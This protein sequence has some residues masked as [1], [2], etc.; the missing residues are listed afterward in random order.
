MKNYLSEEFF[1]S[2]RQLLLKMRTTCIL[3]IIFAS[4]LLATN[5]NSQ[6]A[7]VN[8]NLKN[9]SV[10]QIIRAIENQTDYLFVYDKNEI[11]LTRQ[12]DVNAEN[13]S[14]AEVLSVIFNGT[15]VKYGVIGSNIVLMPDKTVQQQSFTV[16]GRVTD[17]SGN[18]L[19]GVTVVIQDSSK[20]TITDANGN[21]S[22]GNVPGNATLLFSFVGMKQQEI[23]VAGKNTINVMMIE[24]TIGIE[25]VVAVG[26]GTVKKSD[27]TGSV[28]SVSS[29]S[30]LDQPASSANS[31]LAGRAPGVTVR[32]MNG[33][34]GEGWTIRIRGANSL[35]GGNDPLVVVD[36]NYSSIPNMY[37]I[38]SIEILKDA[39]ATAIYGSRGAN[40]VI[41]VK[42]KRGT[43]G[44]PKLSF[45]SDF[46]FD[47]VPQRY[48]LMDAYEFAEFNNSAGAYPF[49][50]EEIAYYKT[51]RGTNWQNEILQTGFSQ[52][53]KAAFSGGTKNVRFYVSP[54]YKKTT[55][56]IINT[57]AS[58]YGLS[59]KVDMDLSDRITVQVETNMGK[60][61]N[62]NPGIAQGGGKGS[63]PLTA[64][65][66]W[67]PTEPV[68]ESD[69][70][71]NRLGIGTGT[72]LNP[73]L[74]TTIQNTNYSY[75]GNG[76]GNLKIKIIDGLEFDAK[77]SIGF[78]ADGN[79]IFVSKNFTGIAAAAS[80]TSYEGTTWLVNSF[81]TYSKE[82][83]KVHNFSAMA[84]FEETKG[85]RNSLSGSANIL[86]IES[87]SWYNLGLAAPNISVGSNYDNSAMRSY[88]G[89][90]NYNYD[91]RYY[92]TANFRA[93]GSSKFKGDNQFGYFPSFA[94]A[95]KLSEEKFMKN[96][97]LFQS[98]KMR[99]GWGITGNQAISNYETYTTLAARNY[100]WG[101]GTQQAGYYARVGGN[102]NL[103]WE[104]TKQLNVGF[105]V[106]LLDN[107]MGLSFDYYNKKTVDLLA[108][109]SVPAYNGADSEY[110][111]ATVTS[112]VGSVRNKG[113]EF[114]LSYNVLKMRDLTY[115]IDM[116][117]SFNR[118]KVLNLGEQS[119]IYGDTYAS[120]LTSLSPF[121]LMPGEPIGTIY[122]LKYMGIWQENEA[123]EAAKYQQ[124]PGDY[125]Y[126]DKNGNYGYDSGDSQVIGHTNPSFTWGFNN[127]L[128]YKNL[129]LNILF[130]G[131]NGRDVLN[132]TY[133]TAA[134]R[135][136]FTQTYTLGNA[137]NRWTPTTPNAEFAKIGNTNKLTPVSS[138]YMESGDYVK[139]RNISLSYRIPKSVIPFAIFRVSVSAQNIL[140]FTK[141]KGY[142]PEISSSAGDDVNSG[143]DWFAY[144]N[145]KSYSFGISIEY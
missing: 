80:Q 140:T 116:N 130:E 84:G 49:T 103:K 23:P 27:L 86:P 132:W 6:V 118:N 21:Y 113:F 115:E 19:P 76:V 55:G 83:A 134:E 9:A 91:S 143:M 29:Q 89:R 100:S 66:I 8:I 141:Y 4:S 46:S 22:F 135:I 144:P 142:D 138:Q 92:L 58:G 94:L 97:N 64:A 117:G 10:I 25:E 3:I 40:G 111:R 54:S 39:S 16:S 69:G 107:R 26:Y 120:G 42:T 139:L 53:Y 35:Y 131:V 20:G 45:H 82:L 101:T 65:I 24:E 52:S 57:E 28:A 43:E 110:G 1:D 123:T 105:D 72:V 128:S 37:D 13:Q 73:V 31:I 7:K 12:V 93:D 87:V 129:D 136:D 61:A 85:K 38:E 59:S 126:E 32:R 14:V 122:G 124:E 75:Y 33:A 96:Q 74:L 44:K 98:V 81:L 56:T 78:N 88:F 47:D 133:M 30:F 109:V 106:S 60:N 90:L 17:A 137:R 36:G 127:R 125:K 5:V 112:N 63:I 79:R 48:D 34:P 41:L 15:E 108:P 62:L 71:Y 50:N 99:G 121:V 70:T 77:G 145:P 95:W 114:N 51:N 68:Y 18:A 2:T 119:V 104:S 11:N 102:E 67:S